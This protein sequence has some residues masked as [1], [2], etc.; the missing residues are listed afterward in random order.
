ML[1]TFGVQRNPRFEIPIRFA[2]AQQ[3][4][5]RVDHQVNQH[6]FQLI[7]IA[8]HLNLETGLADPELDA[9]AS[10]LLG[11]QR[12]RAPD[13]VNRIERMLLGLRAAAEHP[14]VIDHPRRT[15]DLGIDAV[16][17]VD[18]VVDLHF[19]AVQALEHVDDG[20]THHVQWLAD[21]MR[22]ARGHFAKGGHFRA[23]GRRGVLLLVFDVADVEH[24][25]HQ[26]PVFADAHGL[27][28]QA[29]PGRR[30]GVMQAHAEQ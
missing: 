28:L 19:T 3:C 2:F 17:F 24:E 1:V 5:P 20:Q 6:L 11:Q 16:E 13:G 10:Q 23:L 4:I 30:V 26:P 25:T 21:F 15:L 22:Q 9:F 27:A 14:H 29:I 12:Q 7:D 8:T 18:Q